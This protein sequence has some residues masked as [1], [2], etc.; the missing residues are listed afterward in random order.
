MQDAFA[1]LDH[2]ETV[3]EVEEQCITPATP[4]SPCVAVVDGRLRA[5]PV[6]RGSSSQ[7]EVT[8]TLSQAS[9]EADT[10]YYH[11]ND[12]DYDNWELPEKYHGPMPQWVRRESSGLDNRWDG[13]KIFVGDLDSREQG[14]MIP[15]WLSETMEDYGTMMDWNAYTRI[16]DINI[17]RPAEDSKSGNWKASCYHGLHGFVG[18]CQHVCS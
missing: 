15:G 4:C 11:A 8:N 2:A 6:P 5:F 10:A 16:S 12:Y 14:K 7:E 3:G 18:S 9:V 1:E 17:T 13:F